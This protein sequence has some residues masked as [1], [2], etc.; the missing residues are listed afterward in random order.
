MEPYAKIYSGYT[1]LESFKEDSL[2][3]ALLVSEQ[4]VN[5][6]KGYIGINIDKPIFT[7]YGFIRP[8]TSLELGY[9]FT[10]Y[11][12]YSVRYIADQNT[13]YKKV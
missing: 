5:H 10:N 11:G 13:K 1:L 8:N 6:R 9:D 7:N 3:Y 12:D 2:E 4:K